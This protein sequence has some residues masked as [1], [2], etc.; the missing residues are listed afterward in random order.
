MSDFY[1]DDIGAHP[2]KKGTMWVKPVKKSLSETIFTINQ[3]EQ[4]FGRVVAISPDLVDKNYLGNVVLMLDAFIEKR[5]VS[6][7]NLDCGSL[8]VLPLPYRSPVWHV[9]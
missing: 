3:V 6:Q 4:N 1:V 9:G 2:V 8:V 7:I 5:F